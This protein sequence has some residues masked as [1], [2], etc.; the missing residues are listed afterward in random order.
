MAGLILKCT[1][2][3]A[4]H[5]TFSSSSTSSM[6]PSIF[7]PLAYGFSNGASAVTTTK[8]TTAS[9]PFPWSQQA[10]FV[11]PSL[12][13]ILL[14]AL[15]WAVPKRKHTPSRKRKKTTVQKRIPLKKNIVFDPQTGEVTLKHR[16][17]FN[18][19]DYLPK[20]G[21]EM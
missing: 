4:R 1:S 19:R 6:L 2:G 8:T 15:W 21:D 12:A 20:I 5:L 3:W 10:S 11:R 13:S 9:V 18:W 17:P 7:P 16:L 14:D